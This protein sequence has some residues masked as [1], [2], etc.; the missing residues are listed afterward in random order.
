M[1]TH[2]PRHRHAIEIRA[3]LACCR[4]LRGELRVAAAGYDRAIA[5]AAELFGTDHRETEAL[6]AER[7]ELGAPSPPR[8]APAG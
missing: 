1:T 6:R 5:D 7:R 8:P 2:G 3:A 4:A